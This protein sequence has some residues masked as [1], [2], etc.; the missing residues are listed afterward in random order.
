[1]CGETLLLTIAL[2]L[3]QEI[4]LFALHVRPL[5]PFLPPESQSWAQA[6]V[7]TKQPTTS[8][9]VDYLLFMPPVHCLQLSAIPPSR[10]QAVTCGTL[11]VLSVTHTSLTLT[12]TFCKILKRKNHTLD[13]CLP[14]CMLQDSQSVC[15]LVNAS[16]KFSLCWRPQIIW[17]YI[18]SEA[19]TKSFPSDQRNTLKKKNTITNT[20]IQLVMKC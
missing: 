14:A 16:C 15:L 7:L 2:Q 8:T 6:G 10:V 1:M 20:K 11:E 4:G 18:F 17:C 19:M 5:P 13:L 3:G 12:V 9:K